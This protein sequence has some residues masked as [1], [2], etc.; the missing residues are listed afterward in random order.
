MTQ[1]MKWY[2]KYHRLRSIHVT[3]TVL[4]NG[5]EAVEIG[6]A[7]TEV[8][9]GGGDLGAAGSFGAGVVVACISS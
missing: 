1:A 8:P 6:S 4:C 9:R 3:P 7:W 5:L 2:V